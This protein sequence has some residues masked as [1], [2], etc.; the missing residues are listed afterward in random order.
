MNAK[1]VDLAMV[2]EGRAEL[3][4][5]RKRWPRLRGPTAA[6]RCAAWYVRG[7]PDRDDDAPQ[8]RAVEVDSMAAKKSTALRLTPELL[9]KA[10]ALVPRIE[11]SPAGQ[12]GRITRSAVLRMALTEGLT[13]LERRYPAPPEEDEEGRVITAIVVEKPEPPTPVEFVLVREGEAEEPDDDAPEPAAEWLYWPGYQG[14]GGMRK[15]H[16]LHTDSARTLCGGF[17]SPAGPSAW[18]PAPGLPRCGNCQRAAAKRDGGDG[19]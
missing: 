7:G 15:S 5:A 9:A 8:E 16:R 12:W 13:A 17:E 10:D 11:A 4:A 19:A 3:D 14:G 6:A 1:P 18:E 2:R